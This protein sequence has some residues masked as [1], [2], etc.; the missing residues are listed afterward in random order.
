MNEALRIGRGL[1]TMSPF[2][3]VIP[4]VAVVV[5]LTIENDPHGPIFIVHGLLAPTHIDDRQST[6][7]KPDTIP[8]V[9]PIVIWSTPCDQ[10]THAPDQWLIDTPHLVSNSSNDSTHTISD[11]LLGS[12]L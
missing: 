12:L 11:Y 2:K 7:A 1:E 5:D 9:E 4:E 3:K 6:H 8:E 10:G